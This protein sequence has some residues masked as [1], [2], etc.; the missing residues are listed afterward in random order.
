MLL[1]GPEVAVRYPGG[2]R[3]FADIDL[4]VPNAGATQRALI[5]A[6]F[7]EEDD[8]EGLYVGIHHLPPVRWPGMMLTIEVHSE[9]KWPDGLRRPAVEQLLERGVA[10]SLDVPGILAP[11]PAAH[12]LLLAAHAWA[13]QPLASLRD[14][15]DVGA[16][17]TE[18]ERAEID[19]LARSWSLS[20]VFETMASALEAALR[21]RRTVPLRLWAGHIPELR[22]QIVLEQHLERV[23]S[24]FW[25]L[26]P[27]LAMRSSGSALVN[28]FRPAFD[29]TWREKV[30][31]TGKAV[32]RWAMSKTAHDRLLGESATRGR[33]R[34]PRPA[35]DHQGLKH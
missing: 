25:G 34:N 6:G 29:E 5:A 4:L 30:W 22:D 35:K 27:L 15:L 19:L 17:A 24:P 8:P 33:K 28:E 3:T 16:V 13:H 10:S 2:A 9:P 7:V 32:R 21:G 12:A 14:L 31:R 1:K 20:R 26:P 11:D 23:V 18:A